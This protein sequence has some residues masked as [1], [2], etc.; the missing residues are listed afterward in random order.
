MT[1][2]PLQN[3]LKNEGFAKN[4]YEHYHF[5]YKEDEQP[6]NIMEAIE[7]WCVVEADE[8]HLYSIT[9]IGSDCFGFDVV[10]TIVKNNRMHTEIINFIEDETKYIF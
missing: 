6:F 3:W 4:E 8:G 2:K 5:I 10:V 7:H 9:D 1:N